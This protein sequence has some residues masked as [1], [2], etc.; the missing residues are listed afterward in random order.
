MIVLEIIYGAYREDDIVKYTSQ[1]IA[2]KAHT[3]NMRNKVKRLSLSIFAHPEFSN[4]EDH[5]HF[6][7]D[8][9]VWKNCFTDHS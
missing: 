9:W 3:K 5:E 1:D 6:N 2:I 7:F 4:Y 8:I